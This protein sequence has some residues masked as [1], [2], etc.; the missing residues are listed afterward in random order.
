[1]KINKI[2]KNKAFIAFI[3][4]FILGSLII[5]PWIIKGDGIYN[6]IADFNAQQI[7]FN[8][9]INESIKEGSFLW[10]WYNELGSNFI[11]TFSF[12][13]LFSPFNIITYIFPANW[14]EYLIGPIFILKYAVAGLTSYL[15]IQRYV[16]NKKYAILG[17]VLYSFSGFQLTN[18]LFYHFHDVVAL[19]PLLLYSLDKLVYENKKF[20]FGLSVA[21]L[22]F[23]N[24]FFFIGEVVFV[25]LYYAVKVFTKSYKFNVKKLLNI[26]FEAILGVG[27]AAL[28]LIPS[29]LF[30][31]SNPRVSNSWTLLTSLKY[32]FENYLDILRSFIFPSEI[33]TSRAI[34]TQ[35]NYSSTEFFLPFVGIVLSLSYF[36]KKPKSWDSIFMVLLCFFIFIPILNSSFFAFTTTYYSRWFYMAIL[37]FALTSARSLDENISIK[38]GIIINFVLIVLF[39]LALYIYIN[40]INSGQ[41]IFDRNYLLIIIFVF[42]LCVIGLLFIDMINN[43]NKFKFV[44]LFVILYVIVW[45]NY[46]NYKYKSIDSSSID[47]YKNYLYINNS[48]GFSKIVRANS[49]DSCPYNLGLLTKTSN[50]KSWNSNINGSTFK[51]YNSIGYGRGVATIINLKDEDLNDFLG[52][53]YIID[54]GN[55]VLDEG[56]EVNRIANNYVVY[57]NKDF[58]PIGFNVNKYISYKEYNKLSDD[59][60]KQILKDTVVLNEEQIIKYGDIIEN[61]DNYISNHYKFIKNGFESNIEASTDSFAV[62]SIPYDKG[63]KITN[64]GKNIKFEEVDNGFIG[65][66]IDKG[67]NNIKFSYFP[68]GLKS[69][70]IVSIISLI[71]FIIYVIINKRGIEVKHEK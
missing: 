4:S 16:K 67:I 22:A 41:I 24:W 31:M 38:K 12:Y 56:Y 34:L 66:K 44:L 15:F 55:S 50:I 71:T 23:T 26:I 11:G 10:T 58:N 45:G 61:S 36:V 42:L 33:M 43:E 64:N 29:V 69:G 9:I 60:K 63:W 51:F 17:S 52:V 7:P 57:N 70:I 48:L 65:I 2:L 5:V 49:S 14:Y 1:M 13:N 27:L 6:L 20:I 68:P 35:S 25:I 32:N 53:E 3:L 54:C 21:L 30:T 62:Y 47:S 19:F 37:I 40:K 59:E 8:K 39:V 28:V 18:I 46:N